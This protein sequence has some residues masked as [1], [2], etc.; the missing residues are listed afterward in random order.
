MTR[1]FPEAQAIPRQESSLPAGSPCCDSPNEGVAAIRESRNLP[2]ETGSEKR[3]W[4]CKSDG[5]GGSSTAQPRPRVD[6]PPIPQV[7]APSPLTIRMLTRSMQFTPMTGLAERMS[8]VLNELAEFAGGDNISIG[9]HRRGLTG[10][11]STHGARPAYRG[12]PRR[13]DNSTLCTVGTPARSGAP[14]RAPG[15]P[16][17]ALPRPS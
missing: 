9:G 17:G 11:C 1:Y 3:L 2:S 12:I 10:S 15:T 6:S 13:D 16:L 4:R 8:G 5:T 7:P 14:W